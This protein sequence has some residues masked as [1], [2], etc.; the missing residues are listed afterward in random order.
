MCP[1]SDQPLPTSKR[2]QC[3]FV[4]W[5][6]VIL[7]THSVN[8]MQVAPLP[9]HVLLQSHPASPLLSFLVPNSGQRTQNH[10]LR[11]EK[12]QTYQFSLAGALPWHIRG[13]SNI[14]NC[15]GEG[16]SPSNCIQLWG[17]VWTSDE[18]AF[19]KGMV[20]Q[21]FLIYKQ[22]VNALGIPKVREERETVPGLLFSPRLGVKPWMK[23]PGLLLVF[24]IKQDRLKFHWLLHQLE[25][26]N[27]GGSN[28]MKL[29][30]SCQNLNM[31]WDNPRK[32]PSYEPRSAAKL[33]RDS[34]F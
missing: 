21:A 26:N 19:L 33:T 20:Q 18:L 2:K 11:P 5:N 28:R 25:S 1:L 16:R 23:K 15:Q 32:T 3:R 9:P 30:N 34:S 10:C 29:G 27:F 24:L 17:Q 12:L 7:I 31:P 14:E 4:H 8:R 6:R 22:V 13:E